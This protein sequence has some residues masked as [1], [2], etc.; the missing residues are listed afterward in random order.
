MSSKVLGLVS[1]EC[2]D[3]FMAFD[4]EKSCVNEF[5]VNG[6]NMVIMAPLTCLNC[7]SSG[8]HGR[9]LGCKDASN[10]QDLRE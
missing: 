7:C 6:L 9:R 3:K 1:Q 2:L 5:I 10:H 8:Y 4:I